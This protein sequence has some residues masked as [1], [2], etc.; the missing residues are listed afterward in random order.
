MDVVFSSLGNLLAFGG[1]G[2]YSI[3]LVDISDLEKDNIVLE[4]HGHKANI[5]R[6]VFSY[7]SRYLI[8][9]SLNY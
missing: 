7:N 2:D 6:L 5:E 1:G 8:S 9:G 4:L 3:K